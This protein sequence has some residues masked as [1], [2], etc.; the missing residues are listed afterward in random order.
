MLTMANHAGA[1]EFSAYFGLGTATN[2]A[3]TTPGC[4]SK[5]IFDNFTGNCEAAPSLGVLFGV[6][7]ADYM[8]GTRLGF[9]GEYAFRFAQKSYLPA[10]GIN[11]RH[12]FYD[13]NALYQPL[14]Q[15]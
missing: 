12:E 8:F 6:F 10:A 9:N 3:G 13:F 1:Q 14:S 5:F 11:A 4:A 2:S 15:K 7:V